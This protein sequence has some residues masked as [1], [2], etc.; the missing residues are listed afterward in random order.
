MPQSSLG[1]AIHVF[2]LTGG[3]ATG[4]STVAA[5]W[6]RRGLPVVDADQLARDVVAPGTDGL[7]AVVRL[8][9]DSVLDENGNLNRKQVGR[10]VFADSAARASLEALLH[11]LIDVELRT[12]TH[13]FEMRGEPLACYEAPLLVETG[14]A[15]AF[16]PLV[17]V[18]ADETAQISR[19]IRRDNAAEHEIR[20]RISAQLPLAK[21]A[22]LADI[23]IRNE[24][25][26]QQLLAQADDTLAA[27]CLRLSV[28]AR[29]YGY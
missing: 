10:L 7:A 13:E 22:A 27:I 2:G 26:Y 4:K 20:A 16:R 11:P 5:Q 15:G 21:K 25:S 18:T 1:M 23:L 8:F 29:R 14:R 17:L 12:K 24:G 3:I 19:V 6:R 9:G 28:D